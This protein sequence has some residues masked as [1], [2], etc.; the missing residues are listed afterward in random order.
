M[1]WNKKHYDRKSTKHETDLGRKF[2]EQKRGCPALLAFLFSNPNRIIA[3]NLFRLTPCREMGLSTEAGFTKVSGLPYFALT[4]IWVS[5]EHF[6]KV[7]TMSIRSLKSIIQA[8]LPWLK[9]EDLTTMCNPLIPV[10]SLIL[11]VPDI[12][13]WLVPD[14]S[15][16]N[17]IC[18]LLIWISRYDSIFIN[19]IIKS[20]WK[21]GRWLV[22]AVVILI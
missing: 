18:M 22:S 19:F 1:P 15:V 4:F 20:R 7:G 21:Y 16:V 3:L 6:Q 12:P 2:F 14:I 9:N 17:N 13:T 5:D 10:Q 11:Y 8:K